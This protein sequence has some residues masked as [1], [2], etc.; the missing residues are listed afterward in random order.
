MDWKTDWKKESAGRSVENGSLISTGWPIITMSIGAVN[1][2][3]AWGALSAKKPRSLEHLNPEMG[4]AKAVR[5]GTG[6]KK[7]SD[8]VTN[9]G[10]E[11]QNLWGRFAWRTDEKNGGGNCR[12]PIWKKNRRTERLEGMRSK[13]FCKGKTDNGES[14]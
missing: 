11:V 9:I 8:K 1:H 12:G 2:M 4:W 5:K 6:S 13:D 14:D 7:Q 10:G 3:Q